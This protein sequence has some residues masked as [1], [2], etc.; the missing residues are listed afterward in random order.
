MKKQD[1]TNI[2]NPVLI[3][4]VLCSLVLSMILVVPVNTFGMTTSDNNEMYGTLTGRVT[5]TETKETISNAVM[6][7]KYHD[8]IRIDRTDAEGWYEFENV[9]ICFCLKNISAF[10]EGYEPEYQLVGVSTLTYANFTLIP[11]NSNSTD[12]DDPEEPEDPPEDPPE[13]EIPDDEEPEEP[14]EDP[15]PTD[16][17]E[18][19]GIITG[20]VID[21]NTNDPI[22]GATVK[23]TCHDDIRSQMTDSNGE[24]L[25]NKVPICFCLKNVSV[26]MRGYESQYELVAV[27]EITWANFTLESANSETEDDND[28]IRSGSNPDDVNSLADIEKEGEDWNVLYLLLFFIGTFAGLIIFAL[29]YHAIGKEVKTRKLD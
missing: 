4:G 9:P 26:S 24:Y 1:N 23:L 15:N 3:L 16:D 21:A 18:L 19:Y 12:P 17:S 7:L 29:I 27:Y 20:V 22:P 2:K 5:D 6:T 14:P 10:K 8:L 28:E 13:D 25:F 11:V